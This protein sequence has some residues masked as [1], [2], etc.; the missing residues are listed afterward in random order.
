MALILASS[1][2]KG[3]SFLVGTHDSIIYGFPKHVKFLV[4]TGQSGFPR[5]R[6]LMTN[7]QRKNKQWFWSQNR[8]YLIILKQSTCMRKPGCSLYCMI[9]GMHTIQDKDFRTLS[10]PWIFFWILMKLI[11]QEQQVSEPEVPT[12]MKKRIFHYVKP[13]YIS[14]SQS[15]SSLHAL[16]KPTAHGCNAHQITQAAVRWLNG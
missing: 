3:G 12:A 10:R 14:R 4:K 6:A 7:N 2:P 15:R 1:V 8:K 11:L 16:G 9:T 13:T 5:I